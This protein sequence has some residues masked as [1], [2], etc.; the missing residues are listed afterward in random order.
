MM[1]VSPCDAAA[2]PAHHGHDPVPPGH[3]HH[4]RH[5]APRLPR[6]VPRHQPRA[7]GAYC[8]L[9]C[10]LY[11]YCVIRGTRCQKKIINVTRSIKMSF[12]GLK[13]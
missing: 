7:P 4:V 11:I 6:E 1:Q 8:L 12:K 5:V 9:Y 3:H 10:M 13:V 2:A